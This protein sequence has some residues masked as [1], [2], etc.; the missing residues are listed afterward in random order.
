MSFLDVQIRDAKNNLDYFYFKLFFCVLKIIF[1]IIILL[2]VCSF[3]DYTIINIISLV[4]LFYLIYNIFVIYKYYFNIIN[5]I[6]MTL[7]INDYIF[8][9]D[10][11]TIN[12]KFFKEMIKYGK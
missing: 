6:K 8:K 11:N 2:V 4:Y 12:R 5:D 10:F 7:E 9:V 1:K 3:F